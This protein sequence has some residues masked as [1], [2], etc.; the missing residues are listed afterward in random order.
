VIR[1]EDA[2]VLTCI[3]VKLWPRLGKTIRSAGWT[4]WT[5]WTDWTG[6]EKMRRRPGRTRAKNSGLLMSPESIQ[7]VQQEGMMEE[8]MVDVVDVVNVP[9]TAGSDESGVAR[10]VPV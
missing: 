1:E 7:P 3:D 2:N 9:P 10:D 5:D 4:D 8:R 6:S